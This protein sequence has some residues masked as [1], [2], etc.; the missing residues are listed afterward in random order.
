M[1]IN[2]NIEDIDILK[3]ISHAQ[4]RIQVLTAQLEEEEQTLD[5]L[6]IQLKE[7]NDEAVVQ[8]LIENIAIAE[9]KGER[10]NPPS[11]LLEKINLK[12]DLEENIEKEI[13]G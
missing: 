10:K 4:G 8:S 11:L 12:V 5:K 9:Q 13:K 6:T 2:I 7:K 1:E 3:K